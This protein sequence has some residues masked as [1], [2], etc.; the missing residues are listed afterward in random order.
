M[1]AAQLQLFD[2][3]PP[4]AIDADLLIGDRVVLDVAGQ[5]Y[6]ATAGLRDNEGRVR[7]HHLRPEPVTEETAA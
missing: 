2:S 3:N 5:R 4:E 7:L 6:T 1:T